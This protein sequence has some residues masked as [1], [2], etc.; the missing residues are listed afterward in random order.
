MPKL[1]EGEHVPSDKEMQKAE[2][3]ITQK[4]AHL[5]EIRAER[6]DIALIESTFGTEFGYLEHSKLMAGVSDYV[7]GKVKG[8][9][10]GATT[11]GM[12]VSVDDIDT[13]GE[14]S[15]KL[16]EKFGAALRAVADDWGRREAKTPPGGR[17]LDQKDLNELENE[18]REDLK[19]GYPKKS[20]GEEHQER[21][22]IVQETL[23]K[24]IS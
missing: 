20:W 9:R 11:R 18:S 14:D 16:S 23:K 3:Q 5:S 4:Q 15:D 10:I 6:P 8:H 7:F 21:Q 19:E 12:V 1:S 22:N 2:N 24:A 17:T 13:F